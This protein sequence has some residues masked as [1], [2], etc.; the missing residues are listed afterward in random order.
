ME[1]KNS[2]RKFIKNSV[3]LSVGLSLF[4]NSINAINTNPFIDNY[5]SK[6]SQKL[7][8]LILG[9]TSFLGPHQI[10]YALQRGHQISTFT[11][12]KTK[13]KIHQD[14]FN[15]V[16]SLIGDRENDLSALENR[17]WDVVIDNSGR[18]VSW[19]KKTAALLK[20]N[21]N[22]Y[23]YTS[24][25]GVYYPYLKDDITENTKLL[26]EEP[27]DVVDEDMKMEYWYGV[28]KSNS[29][30]A[31]KKIFG[32]SNTLIIRPTYMLG[33]G[34]KFD[35]FT[36][37]PLKFAQ[38]GK[39]LVPGKANDL[40]QYIDVRDVA[41]WTIRLIE[42][43]TV[44]TFNAV[45]PENKETMVEFAK[46]AQQVFSK[47]TELTFIDDYNFLKKHKVPYLI[48][49][50][51]PE[52]NNYGTA[53]INNS[54]AKENG[55]TFR[56]LDTIMKEYYTWWQSDAVSKERKEKFLNSKESVAVRDQAIIKQW[57][58]Q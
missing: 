34:D 13:P 39:V 36:Y 26:L 49:W 33:P 32:K 37:W 20:D 57:L 27:D 23:V 56:S 3:Q 22:T 30:L 46:K 10:A 55:L 35:R 29:E 42:N 17:K 58:N 5:L 54:L 6:P 2:R 51:M 50:V 45:G 43:N 9:G 12:G 21:V 18:K 14:I 38:G 47:K 52:G 24:S 19:T 44:G 25:T 7:N 48:P 4:G 41:E 53:R 40:V 31:A 11:R 16:E 1:P 28:M 15:K 8:I